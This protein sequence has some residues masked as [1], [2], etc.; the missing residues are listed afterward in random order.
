MRYAILF[1]LTFLFLSQALAQQPDPNTALQVEI[2]MLDQAHA[3]AIFKGDA[4]ALDSLMDDEVTVNHPTNRIVKEKQELLDLIKQGV[5]RYTAFERTPETFLFFDDMVV[6]MGSEVVVP[7][8]GAPN[9]ERRIQRRYT[10]IWMKK[11]G[12]WRL[13]VRHANN[14]CSNL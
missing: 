8:K 2:K 4:L 11:D 9:A 13:T 1:I 12:K 14:V 7:A 6:V 10:N 3:T 5:I